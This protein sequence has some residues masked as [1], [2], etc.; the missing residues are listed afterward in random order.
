M[1]GFNI[2][3]IF[4]N[5]GKKIATKMPSKG[6]QCYSYVGVPGCAIEFSVPGSVIRKDGLRQFGNDHLEVD[7]RHINGTFKFSGTFS[8]KVS[9]NG[10]QI[11]HQQIEINTMTGNIEG[12]TLNQM[13]NTQSIIAG[14]V[15]ITYGFYDA[16]DAVQ[17]RAGLP[18]SDQCWV[19][20]SPN[21]SSWMGQLAPGGS[22][23]AD[24]PFSKWMLPAAHDI[25]MNSMQN[26][27]AVLHSDA[28]IEVMKRI[29]PVVAKIAGMMTREAAKAIAPAIIEGLA[30]TQKDTVP[31]ILSIGARY[32]EFRPAYLHNE[33]RDTAGIPND[34]Y[35]QH[36]AIPGM[37]YAQ[38]LREVV[39]FLIQHPEEIVVVQLRWDGVPAECARPNDEDMLN[40]LNAAL[41]ASNGSIQHGSLDDMLNKTTTQLRSES[42]R[43]I[44]FV[45][46]DSFSTY[47]DEGNA[48]ING[49][50]LIA[51]FNKI[52]PERQSGHAFTNLQC[53]ATATNIMD[54]VVFSILNTNASS[55]CLLA[56]KP[57]CDSKTLPWIQKEAGRLI[58]GQLVVVMNDFVDGATADVCVEWS[59]RRLE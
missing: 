49:D 45:N 14:D 2:K 11:A 27:I 41:A 30:I 46:S 16:P 54:V 17:G 36:S 21:Y 5:A 38:F 25:G 35:F 44:L 1:C 57:I 33:I 40:H 53:Q 26:S 29:N 22:P 34:L 9:Q 20:V 52:S 7:K 56:T 3:D 19:C 24:K 55:S 39:D 50:S 6:V 31:M 37:A 4:A 13:G 28:L 47:T 10:N 12:G 42:K 23:Q 51:E 32:F 58:D 8:F 43:L 18:T 15:I 48:T 59:R